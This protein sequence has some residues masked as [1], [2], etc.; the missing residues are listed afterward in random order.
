MDGFD[1]KKVKVHFV[2][3]L[4]GP[5]GPIPF[6]YTKNTIPYVISKILEDEQGGGPS[7]TYVNNPREP[8]IF[9]RET[10]LLIDTLVERNKNFNWLHINSIDNFN[11]I[12]SSEYYI[13][14]LESNSVSTLFDYYG[15]DSVEIEDFFSPKLLEYIRHL[16]N[17]KVVIIDS[18]EGAYPHDLRLI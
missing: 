4:L 9:N 5:K 16:P 6:G 14:L 13:C 1:L 7:I 11:N 17:F 10:P 15:D 18:R 8:H 2:Y 12:K 3:D